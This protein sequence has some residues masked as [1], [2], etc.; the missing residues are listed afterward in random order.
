MAYWRPVPLS[1][2]DTVQIE[3][4]QLILLVLNCDETWSPL[5]VKFIE[6]KQ[7]SQMLFKI[8]ALKNFAIFTEKHLCWSLFLIRPE[9]LLKRYCKTGVFL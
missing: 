7:P 5:L 2:N 6:Q 9:T 3:L 1:P 4:T 8:G